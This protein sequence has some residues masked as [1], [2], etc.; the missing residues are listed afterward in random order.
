MWNSTHC[1]H[2]KGLYFGIIIRYSAKADF[3]SEWYTFFY[4]ISKVNRYMKKIL[5]LLTFCLGSISLGFS[6]NNKVETINKNESV[7]S[8]GF[9]Y[10]QKS[11]VKKSILHSITERFAKSKSVKIYVNKQNDYKVELLNAKD[12]KQ[13]VYLDEKGNW[14]YPKKEN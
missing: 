3:L 5:I 8:D 1:D 10:L 12:E 9:V 2:L 4:S 14:I 7:S 13:V 11:K 6:Q